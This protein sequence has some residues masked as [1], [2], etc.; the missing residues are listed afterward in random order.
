MYKNFINPLFDFL[1]GFMGF[2]ILSPIFVVVHLGLAIG[3]DGKPFFF[4]RFPGKDAKIFGIFK[5][6]T[7]NDKI[8]PQGNLLPDAKRLTKNRYVCKKNEFG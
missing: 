4:Q 7:F 5:S 8:D 1:A 6:K 2:I 3:N